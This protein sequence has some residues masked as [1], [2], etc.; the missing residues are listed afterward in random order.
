MKKKMS[1]A[2]DFSCAHSHYRPERARTLM[3][4][5]KNQM[6]SFAGR[7]IEYDELAYYSGQST[8]AVFDKLQRTTQPQIEAFLG[9]VERLPEANRNQS[10]SQVCRCFPTLQNRRLSF[11][12][13][14]VSHLTKL[15]QQPCG[16]TLIE[17]A[18][19]GLRTFMVTALA[20]SRCSQ[21]SDPLAACG[22]DVHLPDWFVPVQY[23]NYLGNELD[24]AKLRVIVPHLWSA[25]KHIEGRMI[26]LNG[27][28]PAARGF[29]EDIVN[30]SEHCHVVIADDASHNLCRLAKRAKS[31]FH[32]I[33]GSEEKDG[34]IRV[35]INKL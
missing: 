9:W 35:V 20:H 23:V 30:R 2:K 24:R 15:I 6:E 34:R 25:L 29:E 27:I 33:F 28:W 22:I 5:V 17:A 4:S 12:P 21:A 14:Q 10:I 13:T 26:V 31:P 7:V 18:N 11:D 3:R 1:E 32:Q 19:A 16:L 8:S